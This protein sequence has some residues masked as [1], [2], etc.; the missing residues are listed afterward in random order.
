MKREQRMKFNFPLNDEVSLSVDR[1]LLI[2][3]IVETLE[4]D[5]EESI[6]F[7]TELNESFD[8]YEASRS[9][10]KSM[11]DSLLEEDLDSAYELFAE[12][13]G[14]LN[15]ALHSDDSVGFDVEEILEENE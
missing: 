10:I 14:M 3:S 4:G 5:S 11:F 12:L 6:E 7:M 1:E 2:D 9:H 15:I 13:H 8:S